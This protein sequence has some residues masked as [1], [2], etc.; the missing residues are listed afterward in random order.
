MAAGR[1][2]SQALGQLAENLRC[3]RRLGLALTRGSADDLARLLAL[4]GAAPSPVASVAAPPPD[5]PLELES[6]ALAVGQCKRCP[7]AHGRNKA[8]FGQGPDDARLM[9]IGEAPGAQEDQQGLPFVGPAGRLLDNMLAAVGLRREAVYVTNIVKCRPP[10]NRDPRPEEVAACR[11]WLEAQAR[12]VGPKVICT[13]GRP[14]ALAVL[15]SDAPISAL[16]GNWHEA[17]GA[18]VLPT[19]HPAYLLRSPQRK[20]Q[21]YQDM[22]AL[23][24]ALKD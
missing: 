12:A 11:P 20:G 19:F 17:L 23:A 22:K 15:G 5:L 9:F 16:R 6:M 10:N 3:R 24:L 7:L 21:A 2:V 13:L 8:V 14:A 4:A 1:G 18:R